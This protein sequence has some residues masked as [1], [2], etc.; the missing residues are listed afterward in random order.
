[1]REITNMPAMPMPIHMSCF[2]CMPA[3]ALAC[4]EE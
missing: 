1:M 2:H 3:M 4:V